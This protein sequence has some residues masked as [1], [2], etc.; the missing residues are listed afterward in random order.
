MSAPKK[1]KPGSRSGAKGAGGPNAVPEVA[2]LVRAMDGLQS[3]ELLHDKAILPF[4][5][6]LED[7]CR[8]RGYVLNIYGEGA[9]L[10]VT[11]DGDSSEAIYEM[12]DHYLD[13]RG[14]GGD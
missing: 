12:V 11:G 3:A 9:N 5:T 8:A 1:R 7:V 6:A 13:A 2:A 10:I 4:I 14:V